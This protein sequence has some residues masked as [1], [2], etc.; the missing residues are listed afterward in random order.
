MKFFRY[1]LVGA[2]SAALQFITM[3]LL[4]EKV[5]LDYR[6]A[7]A[8][9]FAV[10]VIFHFTATR[11]F[12]FGM[13][14]SPVPSQIVRYLIVMAVNLLLTVAITTLAVEIGG[15]GAYVGTALS[16][17]TTVLVGYLGSKHWIFFEKEASHG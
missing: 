2:T 4:I 1:L 16:I 5:G 11:Y 12:T 15:W 7:A 9:A 8:I 14:G 6:F 13:T 17:V 10:S 3:A